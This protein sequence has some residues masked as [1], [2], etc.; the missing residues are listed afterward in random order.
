MI[1]PKGAALKGIGTAHQPKKTDLLKKTQT[2]NLQIKFIQCP[3]EMIQKPKFNVFAR[4][5]QQRSLF[6]QIIKH[7]K[8]EAL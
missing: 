8:R 6:S 1:K 3:N 5:T 4:R 2:L 7:T